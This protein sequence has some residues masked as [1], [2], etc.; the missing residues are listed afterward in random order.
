MRLHVLEMSRFSEFFGSRFSP[1]KG[2][3]ALATVC[4]GAGAWADTV[5]L[6]HDKVY[7]NTKVEIKDT[8]FRGPGRLLFDKCSVVLDNVDSSVFVGFAQCDGVTIRDSAFYSSISRCVLFNGCSDVTVTD[9]SFRG[10]KAVG[11]L[12]ESGPGDP[13][14]FSEG[15]KDRNLRHLPE[16][17]W[18]LGTNRRGHIGQYT[19]TRTAIGDGSN[20]VTLDFQHMAV[21]DPA[22]VE[23]NRWE[24]QYRDKTYECS[25][26]SIDLIRGRAVIKAPVKVRGRVDWFTWNP[27]GYSKNITVTGCDF[28]VSGGSLMSV[29]ASTGGRFDR[30]IG[31]GGIHD[32]F[33]FEIATDLQVTNNSV[34]DSAPLVNGKPFG[35]IVFHG[36]LEDVICKGNTGMTMVQS[37]GQPVLDFHSDRPLGGKPISW[38]EVK[39]DLFSWG[40]MDKSRRSSAW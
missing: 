36:Q 25:L 23:E 38:G 28:H 5:Y 26:V 22:T 32:G 30:N 14:S 21:L 27:D 19:D 10:T 3:V 1:V 37:H 20:L 16:W 18:K 9:S 11:T 33:T 15:A 17:R 29:Y 35:E 7:S 8:T 31:D 2:M 34:R 40:I 39:V 6:A 4:L 12:L 24:I 13:W